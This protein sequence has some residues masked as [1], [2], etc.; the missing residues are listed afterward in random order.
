VDPRFVAID[1]RVYSAARCGRCRKQALR[2]TP[3]TRK[4][5][6]AYRLKLECRACGFVEFA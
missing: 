5:T 3:Q 4:V 6:L 2:V 1:V